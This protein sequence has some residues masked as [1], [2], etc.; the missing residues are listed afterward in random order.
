MGICGCFKR[1]RRGVTCVCAPHVLWQMGLIV[2]S[3]FYSRTCEDFEGTSLRW[4]DEDLGSLVTS[5]TQ[6]VA[7]P[8]YAL[9][10]RMVA[11]C[12]RG[13]SACFPNRPSSLPSLPPCSHRK[14][15]VPALGVQGQSQHGHP[16]RPVV[17]R[18]CLLRVQGWILWSCRRLP[19]APTYPPTPFPPPPFFVV[20]VVVFGSLLLL[21]LCV[22]VLLRVGRKVICAATCLG[23]F[24]LPHWHVC[25]PIARL[26]PSP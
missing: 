7:V 5:S 4:R 16:P 17:L 12:V 19:G 22:G 24:I 20:P 13:E 26:F 3:F 21:I 11:A 14:G 8:L 25:F 15:L 10:M 6:R 23:P 2:C 1:A 9:V 18:L